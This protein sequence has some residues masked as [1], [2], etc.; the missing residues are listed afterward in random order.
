MEGTL[1]PI[2]G[3][4]AIADRMA[5]AEDISDLYL[6]SDNAAEAAISGGLSAFA[7]DDLHQLVQIFRGEQQNRADDRRYRSFIECSPQGG[8]SGYEPMSRDSTQSNVA[9]TIAAA[10]GHNLFIL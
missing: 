9:L 6:P 4:L 1:R 7:V 5:A 3:A 10:G 8:E 2:S